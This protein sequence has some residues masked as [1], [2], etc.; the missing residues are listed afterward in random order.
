MK[1]L[2]KSLFAIIAIF[3]ITTSNASPVVSL[4]T[5]VSPV[6]VKMVYKVE[7]VKAAVPVLLTRIFKNTTSGLSQDQ[8]FNVGSCDAGGFLCAVVVEDDAIDVEDIEDELS[9]FNYSSWT[10][11]DIYTV[12]AGHPLAG[13]QFRIY[14][15]STAPTL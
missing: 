5:K 14:T 1:N 7:P 13:K 10:N 3:A 12:P 11:G 6:P 9:G 2:M 15:R 8:G 4:P